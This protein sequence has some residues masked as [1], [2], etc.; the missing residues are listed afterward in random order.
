MIPYYSRSLFGD[1]MARTYMTQ[2]SHG[3]R[4]EAYCSASSDAAKTGVKQSKNCTTRNIYCFNNTI[5][6]QGYIYFD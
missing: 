5:G 3:N 2:G 4:I 1:N 6:Y